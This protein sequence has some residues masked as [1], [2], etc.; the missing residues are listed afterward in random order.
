M[1]LSVGVSVCL[2]KLWIDLDKHTESIDSGSRTNG[3]DFVHYHPQRV[4]PGK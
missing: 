3:F 4:V 2:T 1:Q